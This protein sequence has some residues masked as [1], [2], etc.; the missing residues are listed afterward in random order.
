MRFRI[1]EKSYMQSDFDVASSVVYS[2]LD[3]LL[4]SSSDGARP[5]STNFCSSRLVLLVLTG[6]FVSSQILCN[7]SAVRATIFGLGADTYASSAAAVNVLRTTY[8]KRVCTKFTG[9]LS[10]YVVVTSNCQAL[11]Q[12]QHTGDHAGVRSVGVVYQTKPSRLLLGPTNRLVRNESVRM[13]KGALFGYTVRETPIRAQDGLLTCKPDGQLRALS[14]CNVSEPPSHF[15]VKQCRVDR[16]LVLQSSR[17]DIPQ[18]L[19]SSARLDGVGDAQA[20]N[21]ATARSTRLAHF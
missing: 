2:L 20:W 5:A 16:S 15:L 13:G 6:C 8:H 18:V 14:C 3:R 9:Y 10:L 12:W 17:N 19:S 1:G 4:R 21:P 7:M 11:N